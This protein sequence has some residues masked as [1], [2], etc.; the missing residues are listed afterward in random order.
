MRRGGRQRSLSCAL[1]MQA[2]TRE[3]A[4]TTRKRS[5][6]ALHAAGLQQTS[7][8]TSQR[9]IGRRGAG[10]GNARADGAPASVTD[11]KPSRVSAGRCGPVD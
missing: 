6:D 5:R 2:R 11:E 1:I 4:K 9:L 8:G 3:G 10:C 7:S